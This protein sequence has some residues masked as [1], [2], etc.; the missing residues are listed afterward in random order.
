LGYSLTYLGQAHRRLG[1]HAEA[2]PALERS[3]GLA[4]PL[5]KLK[6]EVSL[7]Q[8]LQLETRLELGMLRLAE[9]RQ[10]EA[11]DQFARA[12]QAAAGRPEWS[13]DELI[14]LAGV[15]AQVSRLPESVAATALAGGPDAGAGARAHADRAMALLAQAVAKGFGDVLT[16]TGS[17]A[18]DPLRERADF[19]KLLA[20]LEAKQRPKGP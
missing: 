18:Y 1:Q 10:P 4:E 16:L 19:K 20:D 11:A 12:I 13:V 9:G 7:V 3:L 8:V 17:D 6:T 14:L 5:L 15:H 2:G